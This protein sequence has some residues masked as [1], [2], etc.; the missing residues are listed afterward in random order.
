[1]KK[2]TSKFA[3]ASLVLCLLTPFCFITSIYMEYDNLLLVSLC[4]PI[5]AVFCGTVARHQIRKSKGEL[6]G[7][8][9]AGFGLIG[10]CILFV[11]VYVFMPRI[12]RGGSAANALRIGNNGKNI[13]LAI[14][15]ANNEREAMGLTNVWPSISSDFSGTRKDYT[16]VP[17]SESYFTDL[18]DSGAVD[19]LR[20]YIFAGAGVM[21]ATNR[22]GFNLGNHNIWNVVAGLDENTP[23][24]TPFLFTR[25][26][27]ITVQDLR[28]GTWDT[29]IQSK[30]DHK[31]KPFGDERVVYITK[32]GA[33]QQFPR[34]YLRNPAIF[35]RGAFDHGDNR[36]AKVLKAKGMPDA[37]Q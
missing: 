14:I 33:M 16:K 26:L 12:S 10:G 4:L 25:N 29:G 18:M 31:I 22:A 30:L 2:K 32:G 19:N 23:D 5:L 6:A 3:I 20:W 35:S 37:I 8:D 11:A 34:V 21:P 15:S 1:M 9:K 27:N 36:N 28:D 7:S 24:D 17:D 13:V